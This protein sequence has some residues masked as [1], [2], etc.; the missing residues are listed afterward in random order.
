MPDAAIRAAIT[1]ELKYFNK[2]VWVGV[3]LS[4]ARMDKG[5][6]LLNG[7]FVFCNKGDLASPDCRAR[8]VACEI[9][10]YDDAAFFRSNA[11]T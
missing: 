6:K 4:E 9:H 10:T 3:D 7:M 11:T 8:Y 2:H 1:D 5:G